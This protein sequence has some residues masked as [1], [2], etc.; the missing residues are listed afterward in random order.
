M[1]TPVVCIRNVYLVVGANE[2]S[3][4]QPELSL[5]LPLFANSKQQ[6]PI[7]IEYLYG[8]KERIDDVDVADTVCCY[9]FRARKITSLVSAY[10]E[11]LYVFAVSIE[12]LETEVQR[13]R[14]QQLPIRID[15]QVCRKIE[16]SRAI[17]PLADRA[18][19]IPRSIKL[20]YDLSLI[21]I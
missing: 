10:P 19:E 8:M 18:F 17:A 21:H 9:P 1:H 12:T 6:P 13:V 20:V 14:Y 2:D 5:A 4:G 15:P 3:V 11:C 7:R 16:F